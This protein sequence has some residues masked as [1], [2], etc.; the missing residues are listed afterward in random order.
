MLLCISSLGAEHYYTDCTE[1]GWSFPYYLQLYC[2]SLLTSITVCILFA[3]DE[4][5]M[6]VWKQ[7]VFIGLLD[8][9]NL[10]CSKGD[11]HNGGTKIS[12]TDMETSYTSTKLSF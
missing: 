10:P 12:F 3:L 11:P 8:L 9:L 7:Q 4:R 5:F 1:N 6:D 2:C